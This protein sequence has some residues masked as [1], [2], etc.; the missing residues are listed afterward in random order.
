MRHA[1]M[2]KKESKD[3]DLI[4]ISITAKREQL[5]IIDEALKYTNYRSRSSFILA[6]ASEEA[7]DILKEEY[8][9][10]N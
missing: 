4:T 3:E 6:S 2:R 5:S 8:E 10:E 9:N 7:K 1:Q